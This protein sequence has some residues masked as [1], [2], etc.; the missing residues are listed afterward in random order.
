MPV[1]SRLF[2]AGRKRAGARVSCGIPREGTGHRSG[3]TRAAAR[4]S[5]RRSPSPVKSRHP[6]CTPARPTQP[7]EPILFPKLRIRFADFPCLH[8]SVGQR[9]FTLETCCGYGYGLARQL[10]HLPRIFKGRRGFT[11]H[12]KRRGALR[13]CQPYL[14]TNRFQGLRSL[15]KKENSSRDPRQ[16]LRVR[17]RCRTGRRSAN[18]RVEAREY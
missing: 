10:H 4:G 1:L 15:P 8:C 13:S 11:G 17:L 2:D 3:L 5:D 18:L 9:L 16:R 14:R 12:R 6:L 7:L